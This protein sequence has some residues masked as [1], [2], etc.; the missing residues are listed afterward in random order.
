MQAQ[1]PKLTIPML[2]PHTLPPFWIK[3]LKLVVEQKSGISP[4]SSVGQNVLV[5][6]GVIIGECKIQNNVSLYNG[7][8]CEAN[9]FLG[10]SCVFTN[11]SNPD[12]M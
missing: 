6:D 5:S 9:V 10:S 12:R 3:A 8:R 7:V 1:S 4:M 11:I 2:L